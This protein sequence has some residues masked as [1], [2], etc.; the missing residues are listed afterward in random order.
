MIKLQF[1]QSFQKLIEQKFLESVRWT[2]FNLRLDYISVN[3]F[4]IGGLLLI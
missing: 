2:Y 4:Q 3:L 1:K